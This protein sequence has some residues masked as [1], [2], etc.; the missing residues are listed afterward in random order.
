M[1][2]VLTCL[3]ERLGSII[4]LKLL[5]FHYHWITAL[6]RCTLVM[7]FRTVTIMAYSFSAC[8]IAAR[9]IICGNSNRSLHDWLDCLETFLPLMSCTLLDT[10][11]HRLKEPC[12]LLT[13]CPMKEN[14]TSSIHLRTSWHMRITPC[15]KMSYPQTW[16]L[17]IVLWSVLMTFTPDIRSEN[18]SQSAQKAGLCP[19]S[20]PNSLN[21]VES[22]I[23][24]SLLSQTVFFCRFSWHHWKFPQTYK[25]KGF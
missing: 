11:A 13:K 16:S 1:E 17:S 12:I 2:R 24:L 7:R 5:T 6:D 23:F 22:S 8:L 25:A 14:C 9:F 4:I 20:A 21:L 15:L 3:I 10:P 18:Y 19:L